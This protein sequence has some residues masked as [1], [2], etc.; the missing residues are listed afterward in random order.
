MS[1]LDF[2]A[3][4]LI[5]VELDKENTVKTIREHGCEHEI[6]DSKFCTQCGEVMWDE[7]EVVIDELRMQLDDEDECY[8]DEFIFK[9][10]ELGFSTNEYRVFLGKKISVTDRGWDDKEEASMMNIPDIDCIKTDIMNFLTPLN[11]WDESK[12]GIWTIAYVSY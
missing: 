6:S 5:G 1:V 11:L 10:Y 7:R 12:F 9:D 8:S 2:M 3:T 4:T